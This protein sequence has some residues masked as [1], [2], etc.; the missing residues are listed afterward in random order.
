MK[1][2]ESSETSAHKIQ[3]L[4]IHPKAK[5]RQNVDYYFII[6]FLK[7]ANDSQNT[8]EDIC[9]NNI[10]CVVLLLWNLLDYDIS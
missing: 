8:A 2:G 9:W 6:I 4:G 3:T 7:L 1:M 5:I 10:Y